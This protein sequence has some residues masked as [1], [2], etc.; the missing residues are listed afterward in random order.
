LAATTTMTKT[1]TT[2]CNT[3]YHL[4]CLHKRYTAI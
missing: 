1:T 3:E 2:K 4:H